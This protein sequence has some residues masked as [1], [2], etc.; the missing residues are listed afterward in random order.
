MSKYE[1][2]L[3]QSYGKCFTFKKF[4]SCFGFP[5]ILSCLT[6]FFLSSLVCISKMLGGQ[7]TTLC[8]DGFYKMW[9]S[10]QERT[11]W[12]SSTCFWVAVDVTFWSSK[13]N[14]LFWVIFFESSQGKRL[15]CA[16]IKKFSKF[17]KFHHSKFMTSIE[18]EVSLNF[19][20]SVFCEWREKFCFG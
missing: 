8:V 15:W 2:L 1:N 14:F 9:K 4:S 11:F 18:F 6:N 13:L 19:L 12:K 5:I 20:S 3:L 7:S 17:L 10:K 16:L